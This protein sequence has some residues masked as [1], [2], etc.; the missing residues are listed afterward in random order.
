MPAPV[1]GTSNTPPSWKRT[2]HFCLCHQI[3]LPLLLWWLIF[4]KKSRLLTQNTFAQRRDARWQK[5]YF[6]YVYQPVGIILYK[7]MTTLYYFCQSFF[8][9]NFRNSRADLFAPSILITP[10]MN[11]ERASSRNRRLCLVSGAIWPI[12]VQA[13]NELTNA[14]VYGLLYM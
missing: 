2:C 8:C 14:V 1:K 13:K 12:W 10:L 11:H 9:M 3:F 6:Q 5:R 7:Y 4:R